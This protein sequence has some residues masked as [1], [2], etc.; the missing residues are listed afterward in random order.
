MKIKKFLEKVAEDD[1]ESLVNDGDIEFLASIGVDYNKKRE[2][3]KTQPQAS[4][5]LTAS[6]FNQKTFALIFACLAVAILSVVLI[7][8]YTVKPAPFEPPI[9]YFLDDCI[10]EDSNLQELNGDLKG[11]SLIV[12]EDKYGIEVKRYDSESGIHMCYSIDFGLKDGIG[13]NKKFKIDIVVNS[14]FEHK[15]LSYSSGYKTAE[16]SDYTVKYT[17]DSTPAMGPFSTITCKGEMQIGEQWIY[18][19]NYQE[20]AIGQGS[21]IQTLEDIIDFNN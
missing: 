13:F 6:A 21:F 18:V 5:Y 17:E 4:Y 10:E 19:V 9:H 3:A 16:L 14:L 1:R 8:F 7:L 2:A 15:E 12:D 11:F 20:T